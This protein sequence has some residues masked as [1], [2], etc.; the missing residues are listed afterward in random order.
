MNLNF[1][2]EVAAEIS[3]VTHVDP[4][5]VISALIGSV[6]GRALIR[7]ELNTMQEL[8]ELMQTC[9]KWYSD[10]RYPEDTKNEWRLTAARKAEISRVVTEESFAGLKLDEK[11]L[12]GFT[13]KTLGAA[14]YCLREAM[15][16]LNGFSGPPADYEQLRKSLFRELITGLTM[17]GG[18]AD[19]NGAAAGALLGAYLGYDAIPTQWRNNL[20][21]KQFLFA[22]SRSLCVALGVTPGAYTFGSEA[23]TA[24][25]GGRPVLDKA[26]IV[27]RRATNWKRQKQRRKVLEQRWA[28]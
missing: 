25:A 20:R 23:D 4:R 7:G 13:Y 27:A 8:D 6:V 15:S 1:T 26:T 24:A 11:N 17:A 2:C 19:T 16:R 3:R 10:Q 5:C 9:V 12:E 18:D 21:N 22:K 28:S 14:I